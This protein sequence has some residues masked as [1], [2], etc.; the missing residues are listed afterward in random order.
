M[1]NNFNAFNNPRLSERRR[2]LKFRL[3]CLPPIG[4]LNSLS[5]ILSTNIGLSCFITLLSIFPHLWRPCLGFNLSLISNTII[6]YPKKNQN[7]ILHEPL[8]KSLNLLKLNNV[9]EL[10][11]LSFVYQCMIT[12]T[13]RP[14]Q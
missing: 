10:L 3:V 11:I 6:Y 9:I 13:Y 8:F 5:S 14:V 2:R 12:Q 1:E 7:P 4:I